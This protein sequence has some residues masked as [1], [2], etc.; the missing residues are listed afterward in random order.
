LHREARGTAEGGM[1]AER[2]LDILLLCNRPAPG[3]ETSAVTDHLD[4]FRRFSRHRVRELSFLRDLPAALDLAQFDAVVIHFS[5]AIGYLGDHFLSARTRERIRDYPGLKVIFV[6][7]DYRRVD[8]VHEAL[9]FMG[10]HLLFTC[11]PQ[12]EIPKVYPPQRLPGVTMLN[13]LTG[14]VSERLVAMPVAPVAQ[15]A[16]DLGYRTRKPPYWLGELGYE[17]WSIADRF[18]AHAAGSGLALDLSYEERDRLYGA[19]WIRFVTRCKAMLGVESGASVFDF[20][21]SLQRSVEEYVARN[22]QA[23]FHE[24]QSRLLAPYEGR[25]R[26]NQISPRC[27]EA[28]A[29][30]TAMV[31]YEGRYS[32]VLEARRHF[33]PLSKDFSN[34]AEVLEFL[35]DPPRMQQMA[36]R[37]Y[38]E[39]ARNPAFGYRRFVEGFD[40]AVEQAF[41]RHGISWAAPRHTAGA[42]IGQLARSP[43]Y[44]MHWI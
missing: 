27:F 12:E 23:S 40:A 21:G 20:D 32:G 36:D 3:A 13:T 10:V 37:T 4:A 2:P 19:A 29:L 1:T 30:R 34:I 39:V 14:Y 11:M 25:I 44:L 9:R 16:I 7:D 6:Q 22:P 15:R 38:E 33:M 35:R 28:A 42:Y 18:L 8:H 43:A 26:Q 17:K 31:L 41:A 5:I 24:V